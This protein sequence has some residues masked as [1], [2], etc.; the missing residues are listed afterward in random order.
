MFGLTGAPLLGVLLPI[1]FGIFWLI[2]IAADR[3][4]KRRERRRW[5]LPTSDPRR[6]LR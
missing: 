4:R 1:S 3:Y 2:A 6:W 5:A